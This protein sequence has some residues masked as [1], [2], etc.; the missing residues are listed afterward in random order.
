MDGHVGFTD[1]IPACP[2]GGS[3]VLAVIYATVASEQNGPAAAAPLVP[4]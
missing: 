1:V 3:E 4:R 2:T